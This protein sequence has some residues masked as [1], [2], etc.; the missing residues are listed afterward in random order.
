MYSL[1][2]KKTEDKLRPP[3]VHPSVYCK[4]ELK[5]TSPSPGLCL[6][7]LALAAERTFRAHR[8][9]VLHRGCFFCFCFFRFS[10]HAFKYVQLAFFGLPLVPVGISFRRF[11]LH[12]HYAG[13]MGLTPPAAWPRVMGIRRQDGWTSPAVS[14]C[15]TTTFSWARS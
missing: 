1:L 11:G 5:S 12:V 7:P 4:L 10:F 8:H 9:Q 13:R 6:S 2:S 15:L 14:R 3:R